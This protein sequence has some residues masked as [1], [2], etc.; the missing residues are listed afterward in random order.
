MRSSR[1]KADS[2]LRE[3]GAADRTRTYDP[4]I[5]NDVLYQLSYSGLALEQLQETISMAVLKNWRCPSG[6]LITG[7]SIRMQGLFRVREMMTTP[8]GYQ[9]FPD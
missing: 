6:P 8:S 5:T 9:Y 4:I 1:P 3:G 7:A 2:A